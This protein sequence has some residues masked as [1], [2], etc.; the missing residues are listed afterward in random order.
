M[1][2][3]KILFFFVIAF[4]CE[5]HTDPVLTKKPRR[6]ELAAQQSIARGGLLFKEGFNKK[7]KEKE[8]KG[9]VDRAALYLQS[10]DLSD[11]CLKFTRQKEFVSGDTYLF[12]FDLKGRLLAHGEQSSLL[13][14][15]Q[16]EDKDVFGFPYVKEI[17]RT[18]QS[19]GGWVTYAWR[20]AVKI[21]YVQLV[22]KGSESFIVGAGYYPHA[23]EDFAVSMVKGAVAL[24]NDLVIEKG[25]PVTEPFSTMNYPRKSKASLGDLYIYALDFE[26]NVYAH[27]DRPELAADT[28]MLDYKDASGKYINKETI[29]ALETSKAIWIEYASKNAPK[30]SYIERVTDKE[31][32][33]YFIACGYYPD[34]DQEQAEILVGK[35]IQYIEGHGKSAAVS[36]FSSSQTNSFRYGDLYIIAYD[37]KGTIVAHGWNE[38]L[39]GDN[40]LSKKDQDGTFYIKNQIELAQKGGG[41]IS[42]KLHNSFQATYVEMVTIGLEKYVITCSFYPISKQDAAL[43]LLNSAVSSLKS[44]DFRTVLRSF[45]QVGGPF[46]RGDLKIFVIDLAGICYAW[47]DNYR[48]IW[49]DLSDW[50]DQ[51]G[52]PFIHYIIEETAHGPAK[53]AYTFNGQEAV[54][55]VERCEIDGK[56]YIVGSP[57]YF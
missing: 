50:K 32:K 28:N 40:V 51:K 54:A 13:F 23:K 34:A 38:S 30:R 52:N 10:H 3:S 43:L 57:F 25:Y 45:S 20:D 4:C 12:I 5:V 48:L 29:K 1:K 36:A 6:S 42:A 56:I 19:G 46:I 8:I 49:K 17:I 31:G 37:L 27:A 9:L 24:F 7:K 35:A 18:A 2:Q 26:G 41:W 14:A 22:N 47:G 33:N 53:V 15:D 39:I 21:S 11:A 44:G 55:L 16:L